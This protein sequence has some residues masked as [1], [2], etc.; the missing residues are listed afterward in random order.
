MSR[1]GAGTNER[2]TVFQN[3]LNNVQKSSSR[4]TVVT[5]VGA[6]EVVPPREQPRKH[7]D[8]KALESLV[9]SVREHGILQPLLVRPTGEGTYEVVS[10]ERRLR[11]A[12][13][14]GLEEIPVTIKEVDEEEAA[15]L[16]A[17]VENLQREDLNVIEET[18]GLLSVLELSLGRSRQEVISVLYR[19]ERAER[20]GV[21]VSEVG[22]RETEEAAHN[23]MGSEEIEERS[24]ILEIFQGLAINLR[25]FANNKLPLLNLPSD[26]LAAVRDEGLAYTKARQIARVEDENRRAEILRETL[27]KSLSLREVRGRVTAERPAGEAGAPAS[28]TPARDLQSRTSKL[29]RSMSRSK[30]LGDEDKARRANELLDELEALLSSSGRAN[31]AG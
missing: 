17:L 29:A 12:R 18:E 24:R 2:S 21:P 15:R 6:E 11:A 16:L 1:R 27:E 10:G 22:E 3:I 4:G 8:R 9:G 5:T 14:A 25:S 20:E 28:R 19:L 26:V 23:V 13:E 31:G 7:F 30:A